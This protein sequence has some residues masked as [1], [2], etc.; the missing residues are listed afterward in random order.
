MIGITDIK[1]LEGKTVKLAILD[2]M[3]LMVRFEDDTA[4]LIEAVYMADDVSG[5]APN[6]NISPYQQLEL[7]LITEEQYEISEKWVKEAEAKE[8]KEKDLREFERLAKK[9]GKEI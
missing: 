3:G 2:D 4:I 6:Y 9:L 1:E 7:G 8:E 5:L